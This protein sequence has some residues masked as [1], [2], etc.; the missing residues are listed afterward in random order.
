MREKVEVNK[1][2]CVYIH[3]TDRHRY[4]YISREKNVK[5]M[6]E[7]WLMILSEAGE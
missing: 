1:H 4:V 6:Y 5:V 7:S 2:M 3:Y